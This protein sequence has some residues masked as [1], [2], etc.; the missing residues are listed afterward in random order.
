MEK[1]III[2]L[3]NPSEFTL[4][5][6]KKIT[7]H[8]MAK[9]IPAI[10]DTLDLEANP[11]A[12]RTG[13]VT[14][15]IQ[16]SINVNPMLFPFKTKGILLAFSQYKY[17]D[18]GRIKLT[19]D[20]PVIEGILDVGHNTLA[21]GL[22]ILKKSLEYV[23]QTLPKGSKTWDQFKELW[24]NNSNIIDQYLQYLKNNPE[25][26]DLNYLIPVEIDVPRDPEDIACITKYK[27]DLFDICYA[28]NNNAQLA[29]SD[30]ANHRGYFD[31]LKLFMEN[32]NKTLSDR[33]I[34]KSNDGGSI[35]AQ[36]LVALALIPLS[37][38]TPVK[39]EN[40]KKIEAIAP[41]KLYSGKGSCLQHFERIMSSEDVTIVDENDSKHKLLNDEVSSALQIAVDIPELYDYIYEKLPNL[42]NAAGGSFGKIT[43]IKSMNSKKTPKLTPYLGKKVNTL[44]PDGFVMP[45]VYGLKT[46][47]TNT[48][49]NGKN[50]IVWSQP[51]MSFLEKNLGKIVE[52]YS[53]V[54]N[55]CDFDPQKVGK[56]SQAYQ[57][58]VA[59]YKNVINGS[60]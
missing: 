27:N 45:L 43:A 59:A 16:D 60:I 39:D 48:T 6:I 58:V 23:D 2:K 51:P 37:L 46:L 57:M 29:N 33:I 15:A 14:D 17:L 30:K 18:R 32:H 7:G 49:I 19:T 26:K 36:D 25:I 38:I 34:W 1:S 53:L 21:I 3:E 40:G 12:S 54:I 10:I 22:D 5:E 13:T 35:K 20:N 9:Y 52:Q 31:D 11:R 4:G 41:N 50:T 24:E 8:V 47:M 42:Y 28:R 44:C 55:M 56:A